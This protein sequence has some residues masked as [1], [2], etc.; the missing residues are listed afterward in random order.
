V[1]LVFL[2]FVLNSAERAAGRVAVVFPKWKVFNGGSDATVVGEAKDIFM[3]VRGTAFQVRQ[4]TTL[5]LLFS[6]SPARTH[7]AQ[8]GPGS[9]CRPSRTRNCI[10]A[11]G[12]NM[13]LN[14]NQCL[15]MC[16]SAPSVLYHI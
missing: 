3:H 13:L 16:T 14:S 1:D 9:P 6:P 5:S 15:D 7:C 10:G 11:R 8:V 2:G 4:Q 12:V